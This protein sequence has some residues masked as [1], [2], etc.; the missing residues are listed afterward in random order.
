MVRSLPF[1]FVG[2]PTFR[3]AVASP[4][5]WV[6]PVESAILDR[7]TW[8]WIHFLVGL[9][10]VVT[11]GG[12]FGMQD[13]ARW[14][15]VFFAALNAIVQIGVITAFPL[16]SLIVIALDVVVIYQLTERWTAASRAGRGTVS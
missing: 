9:L 3:S 11:A 12:L 15:A 8:G 13:W 14:T 1:A 2:I 10:M 7:R 16:W 4:K 5:G 6:V